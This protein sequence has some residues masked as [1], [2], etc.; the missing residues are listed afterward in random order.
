M[1]HLFLFYFC[2]FIS[3]VIVA[4]NQIHI[5]PKPQEVVNL[6]ADVNFQ[7][8]VFVLLDSKA[9]LDTEYVE[10]ILKDIGFIP[11]I[12]QEESQA[13]IIFRINTLS[14]K[15]RDAYSLNIAAFAN[16]VKIIAEANNHNGLL[17]ALQT[18]RQLAVKSDNTLT[19]PACTVND[20]PEFLWRAFMLDES[21]HFHGS[22]QVKEL[23]DELA[24]L[25]YNVFHWHLVD[26]HGWRI[27]IKK[28][29]LLAEIGSKRDHSF[30][31]EDNQLTH[32][33]WDKTHTGRYYYTQEELKEIVA[34][35]KKRGIDIVPEFEMPGH[36]SASIYAYPWLG[37]SSRL[38]GKEVFGDLYHVIDPN[39]ETFLKDVIDELVEIF[40]F[41]VFHVGGDEANFN[42]FWKPD[43]AINNF[44]AANNIPTYMDL[45]LWSINRIAAYLTS[46][47]RTMMGWNEIT[48]EQGGS[49]SEILSPETIVHFW[50][51]EESLINTAISKGHRVVNANNVYTYLNYAYSRTSFEKSYEFKPIPEGL[52]ENDKDKI[53]GVSCQLWTERVETQERI[54]AQVF[55]RLAS[56]AECAWVPYADKNFD[57]FL[58]RLE[59]IQKVWVEKGFL[60]T[61]YEVGM[62]KLF[63]TI[64]EAWQSIA[65]TPPG[66]TEFTITVDEG[67]YIESQLDGLPNKSITIIGAGADKTIVMRS[68]LAE[69]P[70]LEEYGEDNLTGR[71][72]IGYMFKSGQN[73]AMNFHLVCE[74]MTFKN[75][76]TNR[77]NWGGALVLTESN[78]QSYTFRNCMFTN[79]NAR[80]GTLIGALGLANATESIRVVFEDCFIESCYVHTF[81]NLAGFINFRYGGE[82]TIKNTTFMNNRANLINL[83]S[84]APGGTEYTGRGL[85]ISMDVP[86]AT[87][88]AYTYTSKVTLDKVN[89]LNTDIIS[90]KPETY[91][92]IVKIDVKANAPTPVLAITDFVSVNNVRSGYVDSDL[93]FTQ[94]TL[95]PTITSSVFNAVRN[96]AAN[97]EITTLSGAT[98]N[99]VLSYTS[100]EVDFQM[101]GAQPKIFVNEQGVK[102]LSRNTNTSTLAVSFDE[103]NIK[104]ISNHIEISNFRIGDIIFIYDYSGRLIKSSQPTSNT[105]NLSLPNGVYILKINSTV[106]K[107]II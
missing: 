76:G 36:V 77:A 91:T 22:N 28:Y 51:G 32:E 5:L 93:F 98:I 86:A 79:I 82:L 20:A 57:E 101:D 99:P 102:Y 84:T 13:D 4:G 53:L 68:D 16:E 105:L 61:N 44:M 78:D 39:V 83:A 45:Q 90:G 23:I 49:K 25:K 30:L 12:T 8:N 89:I 88:T 60:K 29:P 21:R 59:N 27:E 43:A 85:I 3:N 80:Q 1:K 18:I 71:V 14:N 94:A 31:R 67:T 10:S 56:M 58:V 2:V 55:P 69:F 52:S 34:Y 65:A 48:G 73:T 66:M 11:Q 17:Y 64:S 40:P 9:E 81:N 37:T 46:K 47:N 62:D 41:E 87:T 75:I 74:N 72:N 104:K 107:F 54:Y 92:S 50:N 33:D 24:R 19:F 35:A 63:K 106:V 97:T 96:V 103:L 26:N 15:N 7:K 95:M 42:K 38:L 70:F 6:N 100:D